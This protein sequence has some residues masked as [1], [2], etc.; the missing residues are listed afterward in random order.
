M[1]DKPEVFTSVPEKPITRRNFIRW[2]LGFSVL[3]TLGGVL[4][5]IV[6]YLWPP[7]RAQ[8]NK[9][10]RTL[11][12]AVGDFPLNSGKVVSV[13]DE[14]V[15]VVNSEAGGIQAYSAICTH[16]GCIVYWHEQRQVIQSPC[17]DG[18]FNPVN[19]TVISG[20]PPR[21]LPRYEFEIVEGQVYVGEAQGPIG[22]T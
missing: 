19:G 2:L 16:L 11:V 6:G 18:R 20:P 8:S 15:I 3:S 1:D 17:H 9:G 12:G 5:P 4:T 10:E 21:P 22:P 13:N 14:P 7:L